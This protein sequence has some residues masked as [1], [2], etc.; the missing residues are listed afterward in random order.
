R[1]GQRLSSAGP[2]R[3]GEQLVCSLGDRRPEYRDCPDLLYESAQGDGAGQAARGSRRYAGGAAPDPGRAEQ[4]RARVGPLVAGAGHLLGRAG[5][6]HV[7]G[8]RADVRAAPAAA[9]GE[10][11]PVMDPAQAALLQDVLRRESR[12]LL[13]YVSESYPWAKA[14]G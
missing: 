11:S 10:R 12:S 6:S 2:D 9:A 14:E 13:Q 3:L 7:G 5:P 1:N 8:S 4:L